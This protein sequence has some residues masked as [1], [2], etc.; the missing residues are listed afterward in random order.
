[1]SRWASCGA[2]ILIFAAQTD[3]SGNFVSGLHPVQWYAAYPGVIKATGRT[4]GK[5]A[6]TTFTVTN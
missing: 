3:A 4:S 5:S 2:R 1:M 6:T